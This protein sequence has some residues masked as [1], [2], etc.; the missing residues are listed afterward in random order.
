MPGVA[1]I[2]KFEYENKSCEITPQQK[3]FCE[4]YIQDFNATQSAIFAYK[5][6]NADLI[7][8]KYDEEKQPKLYIKQQRAYK[9]AISIGN[10]NLVKPGV[11]S[12]ISF[13]LEEKGQAKKRIKIKLLDNALAEG[14]ARSDSN[15]AI[16]I[17]HKKYDPYPVDSSGDEFNKEAAAFFAAA[18]KN[19]E[20]GPTSTIEDETN[21]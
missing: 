7:G 1:K 20:N 11:L 21:T 8:R 18:K 16:D 2:F 5:I 9:T 15:K 6:T 10:E 12:Y 14:V 13:L 17:W 19:L 4:R 3:K